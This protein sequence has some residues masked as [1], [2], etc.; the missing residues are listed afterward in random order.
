[1]G[2][3]DRAFPRRQTSRLRWVLTMSTAVAL[4]LIVTQPGRSSRERAR[5]LV[6][7]HE[8][9][10]GKSWA[11]GSAEAAAEQAAQVAARTAAEADADASE[12]KLTGRAACVAA[13]TIDPTP[14]HGWVKKAGPLPMA[15]LDGPQTLRRHQAYFAWRDAGASNAS[16]LVRE[17]QVDGKPGGWVGGWTPGRCCRA[18]S[19][20]VLMKLLQCS[21]CKEGSQDPPAPRRP[22]ATHAL[23]PAASPPAC[24][25][26]GAHAAAVPVL[27]GAGQPCVPHDVPQ[28][29][30][31]RQHQPAD[32]AGHLQRLGRQGNLLPAP[33]GPCPPCCYCRWLLPP[34]AACSCCQCR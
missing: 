22:A 5:L 30:Q 13:A 29:T 2:A 25:P 24:S 26:G 6:D 31:D 27:P 11:G 33:P 21:W 9:L 17:A 15:L 16:L 18:P 32:P 4:A 3:K 20:C 14:V 1:M 23:L 28:G 19:A 12:P 8:D 7:H 10:A 34:A